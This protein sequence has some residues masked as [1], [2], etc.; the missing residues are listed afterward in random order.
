MT[1]RQLIVAL[2][3]LPGDLPVVHST[4]IMQ[5]RETI[6]RCEIRDEPCSAWTPSIQYIDGPYVE[7]I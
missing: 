1:V 5:D 6:T 7:V 3:K 2:S 4:G